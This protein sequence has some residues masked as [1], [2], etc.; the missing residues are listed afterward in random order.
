MIELGLVFGEICRMEA[1]IEFHDVEI[2]VNTSMGPS[3]QTTSF[4]MLDLGYIFLLANLR[5]VRIL[6]SQNCCENKH[7]YHQEGDINKMSK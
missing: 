7:V 3:P 1:I 6:I 2:W 5:T 4:W